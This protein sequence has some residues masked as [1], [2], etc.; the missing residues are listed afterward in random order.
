MARA[1]VTTRFWSATRA[2]AGRMP[3]VTNTMSSPTTAPHGVASSGE[4]TSPSMPRRLRLL[5]ARADERLDV[6]E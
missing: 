4:H 2:P 1:G 3:G 6:G 5:H